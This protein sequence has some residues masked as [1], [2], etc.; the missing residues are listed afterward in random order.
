MNPKSKWGYITIGLP[1]IEDTFIVKE[2]LPEKHLF[3]ALHFNDDVSHSFSDG[4]DLQAMFK[5][6]AK[7]TTDPGVDYFNQLLWFGLL[8]L[9]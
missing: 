9:V 4:C 8:E 2:V 1:K 5:N 3:W 6:I 7:G